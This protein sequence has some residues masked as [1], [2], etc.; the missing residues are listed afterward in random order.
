VVEAVEVKLAHAQ[1][2]VEDTEARLEAVER[3]ITAASQ[4]NATLEATFSSDIQKVRKDIES[5]NAIVE[6]VRASMAQTD[7]LVGRVVEAVE[8]VLD[9]GSVLS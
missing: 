4:Q 5:Q 2:T 1:E 9:L 3:S 6:T 8:A 7:D